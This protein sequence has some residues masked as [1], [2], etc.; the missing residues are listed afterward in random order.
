MANFWKI[1]YAGDSASDGACAADLYAPVRI[2][3]AFPVSPGVIHAEKPEEAPEEYFGTLTKARIV[4]KISR[5]RNKMKR[6]V[7]MK[8]DK[9]INSGEAQHAAHY[10][11]G[12]INDKLIIN[13]RDL[14][15]FMRM[16][17]EGKGSQKRVLI[18]LHEAGKITQREL[19]E[20]LGIQPGSVSEVITKL[21][22]SGYITRSVSNV[23]RRTVDLALTEEGAKLAAEASEHRKQRHEEMFSCLSAGEKK[24][25][26]ALLEKVSAD[27]KE[28]YQD[29]GTQP[30][31]C[32]RHHG[33]CGHHR[34]ERG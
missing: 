17:Y 20:R 21:E 32:E 4:A 16:L 7:R 11:A 9:K 10:I 2:A 30:G 25:L 13:V 6:G 5:Y 26:L 29:I 15:H 18:V 33:S 22:A 34:K 19:T 8:N 3:A 31:R 28:R 23:D 12:D 14:S 24:E 1:F 27:W